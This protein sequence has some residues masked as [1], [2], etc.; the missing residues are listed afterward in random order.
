M[1]SEPRLLS[2][3]APR[4]PLLLKTECCVENEDVEDEEEFVEQEILLRLRCRG[5]ICIPNTIHRLYW[6]DQLI[7]LKI[8]FH[9][10]SFFLFY[11]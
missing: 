7:S 1:K 8:F 5:S 10:A 6:K 3:I 9:I 2:C 11:Y 4:R